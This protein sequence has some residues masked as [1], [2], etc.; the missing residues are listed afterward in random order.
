MKRVK[1]PRRKD[2]CSHAVLVWYIVLVHLHLWHALHM[3]NKVYY[4]MNSVADIQIMLSD[5][6]SIICSYLLK[7]LDSNH[8]FV[9]TDVK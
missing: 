2:I 4:K 9:F 8:R 7:S 1:M 3:F 5:P 6:D